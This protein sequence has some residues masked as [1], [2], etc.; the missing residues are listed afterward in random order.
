MSRTFGVLNRISLGCYL[1][2]YLLGCFESV[3]QNF[4]CFESGY[5]M[6]SDE[7]A[8]CGIGTSLRPRSVAKFGVRI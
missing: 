4:L 5:I 6:T 8:Q 3:N 1:S 2:V 7:F